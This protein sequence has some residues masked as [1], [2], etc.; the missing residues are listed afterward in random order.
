M[1]SAKKEES[2]KKPVWVFCLFLL[3]TTGLPLRVACEALCFANYLP[4]AELLS[5]FLPA[6]IIPSRHIAQFFMELSLS[7]TG[8]AFSAWECTY[9]QSGSIILTSKHSS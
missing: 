3:D 5:V 6:L 9:H 4:C 7:I 1:A 2:G 8:Q